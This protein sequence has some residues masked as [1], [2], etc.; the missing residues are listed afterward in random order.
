MV[1]F[2]KDRVGWTRE[3]ESVGGLVGR[4]LSKRGRRLERL[5]RRDV[6]VKTGRLRNSIIS[7]TSVDYRGLHVTVGSNNRIAYLHHEGSRA[8]EIRP[9]RAPILRF[10]Q[11]GR[12]RYAHRVWH[13]GTKPNRYLT[14]NLIR[15]VAD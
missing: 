14:R 2:V 8:H 1:T 15:V 9:R 4:D 13:P 12:I 7:I 11:N 6:G 10:V 3:F 5:A